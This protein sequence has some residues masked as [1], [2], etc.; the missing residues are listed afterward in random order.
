MGARKDRRY[1]MRELQLPGHFYLSKDWAE[2]MG[3]WYRK[4]HQYH[5]SG[6]T[7]RIIELL[8][9]EGKDKDKEAGD[10]IFRELNMGRKKV[11]EH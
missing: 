2:S 6:I 3:G 9:R 1:E 8:K 4:L 10:L 7:D 11:K 5:L